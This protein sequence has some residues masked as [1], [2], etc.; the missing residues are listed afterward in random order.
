[1]ENHSIYTDGTYLEKNQT[2]HVEDSAWKVE[3]ILNILKRNNVKPRLIGDIGC[4]A[5]EI[6]KLL[7]AAFDKRVKCVGYD[8]SPQA[9]ELCRKKEDI[10]L[11]FVNGYISNQ[12]HPFDVVLA[13]DVFEH[14]DDYFGFL[15][16]I[17]GAGDYK[18]FHIPLDLSVQ[19]VFRA[20]PLRSVRN[21]LGHIHYFT[22]E[23]AL[24]SLEHAG[25][26]IVDYFYTAGS[27]KP[28]NTRWK[29][30]L[31]KLPRRLFFKINQHLAV[32]V[33][34]GYSLMVLAK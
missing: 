1:M 17:K 22:K 25:Y 30:R 20:S 5:G 34:G 18:V 27:L 29:A 26:Q 21:T 28:S 23:T 33:L 8:V 15:R 32:R 12:E 16:N 24:A 10:N 9:I 13:I 31:M 2:W 3:H 6:L 4:G 19:T 14:I 7:W 11:D